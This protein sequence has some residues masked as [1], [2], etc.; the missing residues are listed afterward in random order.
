MIP[1]GRTEAF[2]AIAARITSVPFGPSPGMH[3]SKS[4]AE[5]P[6]RRMTSAP[7]IFVNARPIFS[8]SESMTS[9][10]PSERASSAFPGPRTMATTWAPIADAI[11]TPR[12]PRPPM[13]ATATVFPARFP[14]RRSGANTVIPAQSRGAASTRSSPSGILWTNASG[15]ETNSA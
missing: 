4:R 2:S 1:A 9:C 12:C 14:A 6:V 15:A 3:C 13:P 8:F 5:I 11:R 10:A 7:P